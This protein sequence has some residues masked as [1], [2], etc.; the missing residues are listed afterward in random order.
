MTLS[1]AGNN[2]KSSLPKK[3]QNLYFIILLILLYGWSI[4]SN[5]YYQEGLSLYQILPI[6]LGIFEILLL[7]FLF[8]PKFKKSPK[9]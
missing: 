4:L 8:I 2:L 7:A 1:I 5:I 9:S 6:I 3:H